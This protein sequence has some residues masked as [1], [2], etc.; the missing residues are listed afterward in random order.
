MSP[1]RRS[2]VRRGIQVARAVWTRSLY[3]L[4]RL[5]GGERDALRV[6]HRQDL[7]PDDCGNDLALGVRQ[8]LG[9]DRLHLK[10]LSATRCLAWGPWIRHQR[11]GPNNLQETGPQV[12]LQALLRVGTGAWTSLVVWS[13]L[14]APWELRILGP[15]WRRKK[16]AKDEHVKERETHMGW[17]PGRKGKT[18]YFKLKSWINRYTLRYTKQITNKDLLYSKGNCTPYSL[19]TYLRKES[20]KEYIH[21]YVYLRHFAAHPKLTCI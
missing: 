1:I 16:V 15:I 13:L 12:R 20:E 18:S 2:M 11:N 5:D 10:A 3:L 17:V 9:G 6:D 7:V 21:V 19:T 14:E 8:E 4:A